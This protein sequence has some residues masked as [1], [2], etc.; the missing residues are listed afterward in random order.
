M[1]ARAQRRRDAVRSDGV[2]RD[3]ASVAHDIRSPLAT[4]S[5]YL[6]LI[7][8]GAF[9]PVSTDT[10]SAARRAA[11]ASSRVRSLVES[12]LLL[13]AETM[14]ARSLPEGAIDLRALLRDV[15]DAL[16]AEIAATGAEVTVEPLPLV[17]GDQS[18]LFRV[19][20]NLV[21]NALK[22]AR[23]GETPCVT[24]TGRADG[25]R[26]EIAVHDRGVGI[27]QEE[28]SRIFER[29]HQTDSASTRKAGKISGRR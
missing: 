19:F 4:V 10:R 3:A 18:Q 16:G 6:D 1:D 25:G 21:Q 17:R 9:G 15:T 7:A 5:S 2:R 14:A 28:L 27:P 23:P 29:F 22:Y 24:I 13:H 26:V 20:E 11:E 8:E 12:T